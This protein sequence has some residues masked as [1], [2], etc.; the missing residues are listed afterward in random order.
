MND[1]LKMAVQTGVPFGLAMAGFFS[2]Q[3]GAPLGPVLGIVTGVLFG[4]ALSAFAGS[5]AVAQGSLAELDPG[6]IVRHEGPAN[7]FTP[8]DSAGGR[9]YLTDHRLY[10]KSHGFNLK[11]HTLSLP[12]DDIAGARAGRTMGVIPNGLL[13][14]R[15]DGRTERFVVGGRAAWMAA[16]SGRIRRD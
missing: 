7:H 5:K 10:F 1:R 15:R 6:E 9:L 8:G 11:D 2:W 4:T 14:E 16:L 13:V 3:H 12:L